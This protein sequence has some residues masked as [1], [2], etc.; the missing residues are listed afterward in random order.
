MGDVGVAMP[1]LKL[2]LLPPST[3]RPVVTVTVSPGVNGLLTRRLAPAPSECARNVPEWTPLLE[4]TTR[5]PPI[6]PGDAPRKVICVV[7]IA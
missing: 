1:K 2:S 5:T 7:G 3:L 4:P 6:A